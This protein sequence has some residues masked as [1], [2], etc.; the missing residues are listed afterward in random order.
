MSP[1][2]RPTKAAP[3]GRSNSRPAEGAVKPGIFIRKLA[4]DLR[5]GRITHREAY[6]LTAEM[7]RGLR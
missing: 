1:K 4:A 2:I 7:A 3:G 6:W 5:A